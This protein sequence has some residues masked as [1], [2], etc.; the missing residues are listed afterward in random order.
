[1]WTTE[2]SD[3]YYLEGGSV[4]SGAD[5]NIFIEGSHAYTIIDAELYTK[6]SEIIPNRFENYLECPHH[7]YELPSEL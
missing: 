5:I 4:S 2:N 1:M 3:G 6:V 7:C